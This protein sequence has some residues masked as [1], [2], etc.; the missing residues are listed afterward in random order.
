MRTLFLAAVI[1]TACSSRNSGPEA[2]ST[3]ALSDDLIGEWRNTYIKVT[4]NSVSGAPDSVMVMEADTANWE[5]VVRLKPIRTFFNEDGSY[6]SDH[7][8]LNDSLLFSARGTWAVSNDTLTMDQTTPNV[9]TYKFKTAINNDVV[10]FSGR[11]DFDED[12][13]EDDDYIGKQQKYNTN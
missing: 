12:G 9:A 11:L 2:T 6:H 5:Q 4:M 1:L 3:N 8:G 10:T 13:A 7:Y